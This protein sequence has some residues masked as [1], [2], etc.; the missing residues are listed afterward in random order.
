MSAASR[1]VPA[2]PADLGAL[3]AAYARIAAPPGAAEKTLLAQAFDD[4]SAD[5]TPELGGD[6]LAVLLAGAWRGAEARKAGEP[7]RITVGPLADAAGVN[8]GY[9]QILILQDDGPFLVDSVLVALAEA[10]VTVRA[11]FHP[12]VEIEAGRRDSLIIVVI[13]PLPQ[14]RRDALG[15][16]LATAM[17]DV[18]AAVRDHGAMVQAMREAVQ[19]LEAAP[20]KGVDP[21]VLKEN[22]EFLRWAKS[23]HFVFLGARDYDYPRDASGSY[24]AEA[25]LNQ[26][27]DGLGVLSDPERRVLRR[28][29]EPAVL[30]AAM[31]RQLGESDPVT[32]AKA[33][34]RSRVHRRAYMDYVGVKRYDADGKPTGETR[35]VGLFTA[36]AYDKMAK[37]VP[38]IRRKVA[39]ALERA[40]KTPGSHN[41]KRLKNILENYPRDE[42]FQIGEDEL[43]DTALGV[44]H[45][46]DRPRI[47]LFTRRDPFD[48]FVSVLCFIPRERFD[49][50]L[51]QRIGGILA[52]AWGGRV[53]AWYPQLSDQPLTRVHYI[54]GVTP[55]EHPVPD[56]KALEAEVAEAGRSWIDRFERAL[57][58]A[59]VDEAAVGPTSAR[60]AEGF[61]V[62]FRDRY[63]AAEA[64]ADLEQF[65][66]L[67]DG[68][69]ADGVHA[70][71]VAV[72]A[73]RTADETNLQ[74]RFKLYR[75][76]SAVPLSDVLP[77]LADMGLKTLEESDHVVRT[78]GQEPIY[79]HDFL[80][81]DPRGAGIARRH[82]RG[83]GDLPL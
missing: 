19:R 15:E 22:L 67:N 59:G 61:G 13:D 74:F 43:L 30:T 81:E 46:Y 76:G 75:R 17:A 21:E 20:P 66:R 2:V 1:I 44:L 79:I 25:P 49:A 69:A 37:E 55:G 71:P 83:Q 18:R 77:I 5:E 62:A 40:G 34:M 12:I 60:W 58:L 8:T 32:V 72:R 54:I 65:D 68:S 27:S 48:R 57:R 70:E 11:L 73:F 33:N 50:G 3:E 28:A 9:D 29:S 31:Q 52:K 47:R 45:L 42:L 10:G 64:V 24:E 78:I 26:S 51:R 63:D 23:D 53:S 80:L 39:N 35:F 82:R 36:E 38:L 14:E 16:G 41:H 7:A 4:Y 56:L 6:D